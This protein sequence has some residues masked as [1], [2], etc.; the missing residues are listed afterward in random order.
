MKAAAFWFVTAMALVLAGCVGN[1]N[2]PAG[3]P[4]A[5]DHILL[6]VSDLKASTAFYHDS[7]GL[8]VESN[9]GH[10]AMLAAG[11]MRRT[12]DQEANIGVIAGIQGLFAPW[13]M[14]M[15][16]PEVEPALVPVTLPAIRGSSA[17]SGKLRAWFR[18]KNLLV[19]FVRIEG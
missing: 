6:E 19:P 17:S 18:A 5:V 4:P 9:D 10:F 3:N 11:N 8:P 12:Y 14:R 15:P 1:V 13:A 7:P 2:A 16:A